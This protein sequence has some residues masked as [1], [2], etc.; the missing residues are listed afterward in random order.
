MFNWMENYNSILKAL[1]LASIIVG[2]LTVLAFL[3][4]LIR[5]KPKKELFKYFYAFTSGFVIVIGTLGLFHEAREKINDALGDINGINILYVV[6]VGLIATLLSLVILYFIKGQTVQTRKKGQKIHKKWWGI[7]LVLFHRIPASITIGL[8]A[9]TIQD[10]IAL[11]IVICLHMIP[12]VLL[13]YYRQVEMGIS[14]KKIL[15]NIILINSI[16][17]PLIIIGAAIGEGIHDYWY[18]EASIYFLTGIVMAYA[19]VS[20]L[21]PE[22]INYLSAHSH[23]PKAHHEHHEHSAIDHVHEVR[24]VSK[25]MKRQIS[26]I[27]LS[28]IMGLAI[29]GII[30]VFHM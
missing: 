17:I 3:L 22:Y 6:L 24:V 29:A 8:L 20:E 14:K 18:I 23:T 15:F 30:L 19:S 28:L 13:M 5:P 10:E 16:F 9:S 2:F 11:F 26:M 27:S 21:I 4:V 25:S 1:I 7:I 12:E